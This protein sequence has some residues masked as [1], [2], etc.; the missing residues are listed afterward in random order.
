MNNKDLALNNLQGLVCL[1]TQWNELFPVQ[2]IFFYFVISRQ[3][4][5]FIRSFIFFFIPFISLFLFLSQTMH[6]SFFLFF[7][8]LFL[9][10]LHLPLSLVFYPLLLSPPSIPTPY[11]SLI[12]N[13]RNITDIYFLTYK[14]RLFKVYVYVVHL[15]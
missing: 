6:L 5:F 13:P 1:K 7:H 4:R 2:N 10:F 14:H 9:F 8:F 3:Q 12:W 11:L 15:L